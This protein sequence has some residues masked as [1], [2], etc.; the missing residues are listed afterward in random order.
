MQ[1]TEYQKLIEVGW[2]RPLTP[3]ERAQMRKFLDAHPEFQDAWEQDAALNGLLRRMPSP[4]ISSNFTA[5]VLQAAAREQPQAR[6]S[7]LRRL[8]AI[9]WLSNRWVPRAALGAAM[10]CSGM[11]SFHEYQA[12]HRAQVSHEV[13]SMSQLAQI[14]S[15]EWLQNFDTINRM[16]KV[17]VADDDLLT[18]LQ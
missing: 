9:S 13:A 5:R 3:A 1:Q 18:V 16:D 12:V 17:K 2:K 4:L 6:S 10:I 14:P 7:W 8:E 15:I 11:I